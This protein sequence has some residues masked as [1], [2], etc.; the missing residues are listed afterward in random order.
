[1][2]RT[3]N[4]ILNKINLLKNFFNKLTIY[5]K[6]IIQQINYLK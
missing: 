5:N 2:A 3:I 1:M 4:I 6:L